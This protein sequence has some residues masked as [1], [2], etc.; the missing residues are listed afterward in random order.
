[1]TDRSKRESLTRSARMRNTFSPGPLARFRKNAR[2]PNHRTLRGTGFVEASVIPQSGRCTCASSTYS[3][4]VVFLQPDSLIAARL[5]GSF[6]TFFRPDF[7]NVP[8]LDYRNAIAEAER[9]V[10][11]MAHIEN[12]PLNCSNKPMRFCSSELFKCRI[13]PK[14]AHRA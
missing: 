8:R 4:G 14:T 10:D 13:K 1:M 2:T 7:H 12:R 9:L 5:C 6:T 11:I 3:A